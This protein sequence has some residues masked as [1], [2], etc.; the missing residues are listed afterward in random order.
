MMLDRCFVVLACA[1]AGCANAVAF[2]ICLDDA[3]FLDYHVEEVGMFHRNVL[4]VMVFLAYSTSDTKEAS[5]IETYVQGTTEF[6]QELIRLF[7]EK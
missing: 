7:Y 4:F 5:M 2:V 1:V 6:Y 3:A